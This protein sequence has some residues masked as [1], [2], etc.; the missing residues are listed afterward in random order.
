MIFKL[1]KSCRVTSHMLI[2]EGH[3]F[4]HLKRDAQ[5]GRFPKVTKLRLVTKALSVRQNHLFINENERAGSLRV[6]DP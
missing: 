2:C 3:F 1:N 6:Y 4:Y 5:L